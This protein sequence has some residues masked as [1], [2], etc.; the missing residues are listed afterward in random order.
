MYV[1]C[2]CTVKRICNQNQNIFILPINNKMILTE[3]L[4]RKFSGDKVFYDL[5]LDQ[6][7]F[8]YCIMSNILNS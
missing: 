1:Y 7:D 4:H 6:F 3:Y 5:F 8:Y 2:V